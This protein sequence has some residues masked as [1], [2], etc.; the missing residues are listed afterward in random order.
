M[1]QNDCILETRRLVK[2]FK[3]FVA[4]DEVNLRVQRG[5]IHALIGPN[6]AGKTTV[7][8]LL[9]KF[10]IPTRGQI[11]FNGRDITAEQPASSSFLAI[12]RSSVKY[13]S[14]IKPSPTSIFA[15]ASVCSLSG[16]NVIGSPITSSLIHSVSRASRA[17]RAVRIACSAS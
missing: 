12:I 9:T 14:T 6:G 3:G 2:E 13:G 4:V 10:L 11:L 5:Q 16:S 17:K 8:N 1:A 15:A 7:F